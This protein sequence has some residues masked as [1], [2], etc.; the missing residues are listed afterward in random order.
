MKGIIIKTKGNLNKNQTQI[1]KCPCIYKRC[2][3]AHFFLIR[4]CMMINANHLIIT[5]CGHNTANLHLMMPIKL[6]K[7]QG[8]QR[9]EHKN[10]TTVNYQKRRIS[11]RQEW[12]KYF[13]SCLWKNT[14][15]GNLE[16][17]LC[18]SLCVTQISESKS[19]TNRVTSKKGKIWEKATILTDAVLEESKV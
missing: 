11:Q 19:V 14:F 3:N 18:S 9:G 13:N 5:R 16:V 7:R 17:F 1:N 4:M 6:Y 15:V 2:R 12:K 8:S 10:T